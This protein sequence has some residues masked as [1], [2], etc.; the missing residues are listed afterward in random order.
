VVITTYSCKGDHWTHSG[1]LG[2]TAVSTGNTL[3]NTQNLATQTLAQVEPFKPLG[4]LHVVVRK[5]LKIFFS[6]A[7]QIFCLSQALWCGKF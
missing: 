5:I 6:K 2:F 7:K 3:R 4:A 1:S